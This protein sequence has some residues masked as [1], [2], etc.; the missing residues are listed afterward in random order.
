[1]F[2]E[3]LPLLACL[4]V[5]AGSV[6]SLHMAR[7]SYRRP[8]QQSDLDDIVDLSDENSLEPLPL[9]DVAAVA[10]I[11]V[12]RNHIPQ[13]QHHPLQ[14]VSQQRHR[15]T[16]FSTGEASVS[17]RQPPLSP[18]PHQETPIGLQELFAGTAT[19][20]IRLE[21]QKQRQEQMVQEEQQQQQQ[22]HQNKRAPT[23]GS[24]GGGANS[25]ISEKAGSDDVASSNVKPILP[26]QVSHGIASQLM[27]RSARGQRN[28][29]VPQIGEYLDNIL[30]I[31]LYLK[32]ITNRSIL[33]LFE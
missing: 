22:S 18:L 20:D 11:I 12:H 14:S 31:L 15:Q 1:M 29:D 30:P 9:G 16:E 32:M 8:S 5:L 4:S 26:P 27:L 19:L 2:R 10:P 21:Q 3:T 6:H 7:D 17:N 13:P 33:K 25:A 24:G 28:Y 23:S